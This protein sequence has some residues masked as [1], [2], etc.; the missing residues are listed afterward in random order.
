MITFLPNGRVDPT[1]PLAYNRIIPI[2]KA[3]D[4]NEGSPE[5]LARVTAGRC[6]R[7]ALSW[8][9]HDRESDTDLRTDDSTDGLPSL[10]ELAGDSQQ[11]DELAL[12]YSDRRQ[13][14]NQ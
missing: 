5:R 8:A 12:Q 6:G 3:P 13:N 14:P 7:A 2:G 11:P 10:D 9:W 1:A 4:Y